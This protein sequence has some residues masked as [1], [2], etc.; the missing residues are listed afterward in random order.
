MTERKRSK[1]KKSYQ[2]DVDLLFNWNS[3]GMGIHLKALELLSHQDDPNKIPSRYIASLTDWPS[4][5]TNGVYAQNWLHDWGVD[6]VVE[7]P[8]S[9]SHKK[10][11]GGVEDEYERL[12]WQLFREVLAGGGE[13]LLDNPGQAITPKEL[14]LYVSTAQE[15]G[16]LMYDPSLAHPYDPFYIQAGGDAFQL[17]LKLIAQGVRFNDQFSVFQEETRFSPKFRPALEQAAIHKLGAMLALTDQITFEA[18]AKGVPLHGNYRPKGRGW[19]EDWPKLFGE[20]LPS[21]SHLY[22]NAHGFFRIASSPTDSL[23]GYMHQIRE[24]PQLVK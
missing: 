15:Q 5:Y 14:P 13:V 21:I 6:E 18:A 1:L 17:K 16:L 24:L 12:E 8:W 10:L 9:S 2:E 23:S 4:N 22:R 19:R 7:S 11:L 3:G 20:P